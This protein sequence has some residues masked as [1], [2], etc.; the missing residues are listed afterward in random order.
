MKIKKSNELVK[1]ME[2]YVGLAEFNNAAIDVA[3]ELDELR[4]KLEGSSVI[5]LYEEAERTMSPNE[6]RVELTTGMVV[7]A[8]EVL[9]L[10]K[11]IGEVLLTEMICNAKIIKKED[12]AQNEYYKNIKIEP[13][14]EGSYKILT[15]TFPKYESKQYDQVLVNR[16]GQRIPKTC[17]Y[18]DDFDFPIM[19]KDEIVVTSITTLQINMMEKSIKKAKGNILTLGLGLGYYAY[20]VSQKAE[21]ERVTIIENSQEIIDLFEENILPQFA[22]KEKIQIIKADAFE[23]MRALDDGEYDSCFVNIWA[24][25][26]DTKTYLDFK[27]ISHKFSKMQLDI[28]AEEVLLLRI[29]E[30]VF[31]LIVDSYLNDVSDILEQDVFNET[32][33]YVLEYLIKLYKDVV[34]SN[35]EELDNILNPI[36]IKK[37]I[38][39]NKVDGYKVIINKKKKKKK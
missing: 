27:A 16:R 39:N 19:L 31:S 4:G 34:I 21:V 24:D 22:N 9:E 14:E 36:S 18:L 6:L 2:K 13:K 12:Y 35:P 3:I 10:P 5:E 11:N 25:E 8:L 20:M 23:Y 38:T 7:P 28:F 29:E 15:E 1:K 33:I 32:E 26:G 17:I 37:A 30:A